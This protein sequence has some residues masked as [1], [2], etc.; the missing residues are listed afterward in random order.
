MANKELEKFV[1]FLSS[2]QIS[3][4]PEKAKRIALW[5]ILDTIG[6]V[7]AGG[8]EQEIVGLTKRLNA[9]NGRG[10]STA[11]VDRFPVMEPTWAAF[12]KDSSKGPSEESCCAAPRAWRWPSFWKV[13]LQWMLPRER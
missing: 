3:D 7:M 11:L 9:G 10:P 4:F 8:Q 1:D 13:A 5:N 12:L 2:T 6:A